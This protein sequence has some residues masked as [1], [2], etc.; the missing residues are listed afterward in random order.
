MQVL[1]R[2]GPLL[3][4]PDGGHRHGYARRPHHPQPLQIGLPGPGHH[5]AFVGAGCGGGGHLEEPGCCAHCTCALV[6]LPVLFT[7]GH[8]T[9][10]DTS[11][12]TTQY[13]VLNFA[14]LRALADLD[15]HALQFRQ[16]GLP[17][18]FRRADGYVLSFARLAALKGRL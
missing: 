16:R 18:R 1:R 2:F 12:H 9:Q 7:C 6:A 3:Y 13:V 17:G 4:Q 15:R 5:S 11:G 8:T 14:P 10:Q